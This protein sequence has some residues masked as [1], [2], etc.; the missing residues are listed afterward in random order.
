VW[1]RCPFTAVVV[2]APLLLE[3]FARRV[4]HSSSQCF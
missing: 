4:L 3:T 1:I 2:T